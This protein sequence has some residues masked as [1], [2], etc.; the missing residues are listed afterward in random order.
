MS[1]HSRDVIRLFALAFAM[2]ILQSSLSIAQVTVSLP[3]ATGQSGSTV[4]LPV[5]VG[6]LTGQNVYSYQ[7]TMAFDSSVAKV[8]SVTATGTISANMQ[9]SYNII[10]GDTLKV[11]AA[12]TSAL[13]GSGT[14]LNINTQLVKTGTSPLTF[15]AFQF[16]E[17]APA[18][19]L[20]NGSVGVPTLAVAIPADTGRVGSTVMIP[21]NTNSLTGQNVY[22]FQ[23]S[24]AFDPT[25]LSNVGVSATN[26]LSS[27]MQITSNV[28]HG[29]TLDTLKVAAA[30]TAALSGSGALI[31]LTGTI[32][33]VGTSALS[34]S[35]FQYN[36]GT[37][38]AGAIN[39]SVT[40]V[41]NHAPIFT[42][43]AAQTV[44]EGS[45]LTFTVSATDSDSD[46]LTYSA[47]GL[48]K[49]ATFTAATRT[50]TWTPSD[51]QSGAYSVTFM[52]TDPYGAAD[53]MAVAITV[54]S[55]NH[56]PHFTP[57]SAKTV[58]QLDS[59]TFTVTAA[60]SDNDVITYSASGLP[61]GA[62]FSATTHTFAWQPSYN[63]LGAY[64]VTFKATDPAGAYDSLVVPITVTIKYVQ[65]I[66]LSHTPATPPDSVQIG[67]SMT[68]GVTVPQVNPYDT[69]SYSWSVN[70]V[71][72][73]GHDSTFTTT[74]PNTRSNVSV[75]VVVSD[76]GG[77]TATQT[78]SFLV[79]AVEKQPGV[80]TK[81]ALDQNYPNPFNPTTVISF[82]VPKLSA[83][84]IVV[85]DILGREVRT[86]MNNTMSAGT[87]HVTWDGL[88]N[89]GRQVSTG[90]Y[91]YRMEAG[92]FIS[93]KKMLLLK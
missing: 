89:E 8:T 70:S 62:T 46:S 80:P 3:T 30:G 37:P 4:A 56:K 61:A 86:L 49:G 19:T 57:V 63:Q 67:S 51:T 31:Y 76:K 16:N 26:S 83:V 17:G 55:V 25:I 77:L 58:M 39:G 91:F 85:Y 65:P 87:Y 18:A 48:P 53:T 79:T 84:R 6:S 59:L 13:S 5:T 69:L 2:L 11:A 40:G 66:I 75:Q 22:S 34:V 73:S 72:Q 44:A 38:S 41:A 68:F 24:L 50:F 81:F 64:S 15:Q 9:L 42:P 10:S 71:A 78:W 1:K 35:G 45:T 36:E 92:N 43:V 74:L 33:K 90:I 88:N 14:L 27:S 93:M 54:T 60:D 82:D 20:T 7:F 32:A 29:T 52:V 23:F 21:L 47:S 28:V 12:G